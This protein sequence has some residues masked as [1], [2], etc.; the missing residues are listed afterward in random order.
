MLSPSPAPVNYQLSIFNYQLP[1]EVRPL[2]PQA[3]FGD[4]MTVKIKAL[5]SKFI[6]SRYAAAVLAAALPA[7]MLALHRL[8]YMC[9]DDFYYAAFS[10]GGIGEFFRRHAEH[11]MLVNGRA[12]VH[13]TVSLLLIPGIHLWRVLNPFLI[14]AT[15]FLMAKASGARERGDKNFA[16]VF[17]AALFLAIPVGVAAEA[18]YWLDGSINYLM[19][20]A[21]FLLTHH[22][23]RRSFD[24]GAKAWYLPPLAFLSAATIEQAGLVCVGLLAAESL[25]R[26][27]LQKQKLRPVHIAALAAAAAGWLTVMLSPGMRELAPTRM[28]GVPVKVA[29]DVLRFF[30][31]NRASCVFIPIFFIVVMLWQ[32]HRVR[33]TKSKL[34]ICVLVLQGAWFIVYIVNSAGYALFEASPVGIFY[35]RS[36]YILIY[37][38]AFAVLAGYTLAAAALREGDSRPLIYFAAA[39]GAQLA[40]AGI[41]DLM[42]RTLLCSLICLFVPVLSF[43]VKFRR[44][45]LPIAAAAVILATV[46]TAGMFAGYGANAPIHERNLEQVRK[47]QEQPE[48]GVVFFEDMADVRYCHSP[49]EWSSYH[50]RMLELYCGFPLYSVERSSQIDSRI[51][52]FIGGERVLLNVCQDGEYP[53]YFIPI[54]FCAYRLGL[55]VDWDEG[56]VSTVIRRSAREFILRVY[57]P[58]VRSGDKILLTMDAPARIIDG[59]TCVPLSFFTD[60]LGL[61]A[62]IVDGAE[63]VDIYLYE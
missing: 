62:E 12:F 17:G 57:S 61:A 5:A 35:S 48:L 44:Q 49:F 36:L 43:A 63:G 60:V 13:F 14:A 18:I 37:F 58:E 42:Y 32:L 1:H 20:C 24:V 21:A 4:K 6:E 47:F 7:V 50:M 27:F 3:A 38:A 23:Y 54:R 56:D 33:E 41:N 45:A 26:V 29:A 15:V 30:L 11:Y 39:L 31:F 34:N 53:G 46:N 9:G 59:R 55:S 28:D 2:P 40:I 19:P 8:L 16:F 51:K 25:S 52:L 22:L 10:N